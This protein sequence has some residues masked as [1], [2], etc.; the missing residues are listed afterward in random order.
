MP[1]DADLELKIV[2]AIYRGACDQ[3]ELVRAMELIARSFDSP[4]AFLGELDQ[5]APEAQFTIGVRNVDTAFFA[6]Y[7]SYAQVDPGPRAFV[8]LTTST[9]ST[10]DMMFSPEMR[11][12]NVFLNEFFRPNGIDGTLGGPVLSSAGRF[13]LVG[14]NH[15]ANQTSFDANDVARLQRLMPHLKQALQMRRLFLQSELRSQ[16]LSSVVERNRTGLVGLSAKG[17]VL[18]VND[19]ARAVAT[20]QD[21]LALDRHGRLLVNDKSA[22][23]RMASLEADVVRGGAGGLARIPRRSGRPA[24]LVVVSPLRAGS[25]PLLGVQSNILIAI[26]DPEQRT[27]ATV[28]LVRDLLQLSTGA[29]KVVK[30]LLDGIDLKDYADEANISINTVKFHLKAAFAKTGARS[31]ADL[32]RKALLALK[33]LEPHFPDRSV[34]DVGADVC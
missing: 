10:T 34:G 22:A 13:A 8:A 24:F 11:R 19:A 12:G 4:G 3:G 32:V 26:H 31:Q 16:A 33:D 23:K 20:A 5:A 17:E 25:S 30:A 15:G 28:D 18:F 27:A 2:E 1:D 21:G 9:A 29:A 14:I 6:Q 7:A